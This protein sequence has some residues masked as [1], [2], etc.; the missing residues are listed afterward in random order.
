MKNLLLILLIVLMGYACNS[1]KRVINDPVKL[2]QV[3]Q[4]VIRRGYCVNDT[5]FETVIESDTSIDRTSHISD[6]LLALSDIPNIT[7]CNFDTTLKSGTR[8]RFNEGYL[9]VDEKVSRKER[10][11]VKRKDH[12]IR[13]TKFEQILQNDIILYRDTMNQHLGVIK[14][15]TNEIK[16][17]KSRNSK[18]QLII[19]VIVLLIISS[20]LFKLY[21]SFKPLL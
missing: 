14:A 11:I 18:L 12:F 10:T 1:V 20:A 5:I 6:T 21:R 13:D 16:Y 3:A 9:I 15:N 7:I 19:G 2:D 8:V 17:L 4:E